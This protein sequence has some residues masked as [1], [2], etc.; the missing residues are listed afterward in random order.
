MQI[1]LK[2]W[3]DK[4]DSPPIK[5]GLKK[6]TGLSDLFRYSLA[7]HPA[8][9]FTGKRP[10][11]GA[12]SL[13]SEF[14][15]LTRRHWGSNVTNFDEYSPIQLDV[16]RKQRSLHFCKLLNTF[17]KCKWFTVYISFVFQS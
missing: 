5:S 14:R 9:D 2:E 15:F 11:A 7:R 17:K 13:H 10:N 12:G 16:N 4:S 8:C 1:W 3:D 6:E